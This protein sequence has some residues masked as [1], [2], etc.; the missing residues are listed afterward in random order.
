LPACEKR[1]AV[2]LIQEEESFM[3]HSRKVSIAV[4][5]LAFLFA[6]YQTHTFMNFQ[7]EAAAQFAVPDCTKPTKGAN[8]N[9]T[10]NFPDKYAWD[11]FTQVNRKAPNQQ[12]FKDKKGNEITT[13]S[14]VWETW[15]D[16]PWTFP[17]NPDPKNPPKWPGDK[18]QRKALV[19][20]VGAGPHAPSPV[21]DTGSEEVHRN[22]VTFNYVI[23][24]NLW[25]T[26]GAAA[27]FKSGKKV[28]F[29]VDS[30][31]VK[32]NWVSITPAQKAKYHWNYDKDG[33]LYGLVAMHMTS[34]ALPNWFWCTFEWVDNPGRCDFIGC[35]DCF[36]T[37]P[38]LIA[39]NTKTVGTTYPGGT[40]TP[41]LLEMFQKNG[42]TGDWG[43]EWKNYRLKGSQT[44]YTDAT[45]RPI[46]LGNSVTEGGFVQTASCMTCHARAAVNTNGN[47]SFPFFGQSAGLPLESQT[48]IQFQ[49]Q[50]TTYNG[51]PDPNWF[52][53]FTSNGTTQVNMQTDFVWA[54]PFRVKPAK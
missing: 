16:D 36:G 2:Y 23:Q 22:E 50:F 54:I 35:K 38:H 7:V 15:A 33:N 26:Q 18:G 24:N 14:A 19:G 42:F 46:L 45:G 9:P 3:K 5:C 1:I 27:F 10:V 43:N 37:E 17:S 4:L 48:A 6:T 52:Y 51:V 34:K 21:L 20:R 41:E 12:T 44:D 8:Q 31:E 40:F 49:T 30:I 11:L 28:D 47:N 39:S 53:T 25:Y 32:A 13:N 29:P